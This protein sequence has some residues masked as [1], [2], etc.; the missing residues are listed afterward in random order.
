MGEKV[1]NPSFKENTSNIQQIINTLGVFDDCLKRADTELEKICQSLDSDFINSLSPDT[2]KLNSHFRDL[3]L[4]KIPDANLNPYHI[5]YI[6][7]CFV[8]HVSRENDRL[9]HI[10]NRSRLTLL[11]SVDLVHLMGIP[12]PYLPPVGEKFV[13]Q[14]LDKFHRAIRVPGPVR[15]IS[16]DTRY[17]YIRVL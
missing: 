16:G 4:H 14:L 3:E 6:G 7:Y 2:F 1:K 5:G 15:K 11:N 13:A 10:A 8:T 9:C 12:I 17:Y